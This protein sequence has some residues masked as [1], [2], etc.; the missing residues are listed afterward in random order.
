MIHDRYDQPS[1]YPEGPWGLLW[2]PLTLAALEGAFPTRGGDRH[3]DH[4]TLH[5]LYTF[6]TQLLDRRMAHGHLKTERR[7]A[8]LDTGSGY[9]VM[10][11]NDTLFLWYVMYGRKR[12]GNP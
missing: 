6:P 12:H 3:H 2:G 1:P 4:F 5:L 11:R 10:T 9:S 7:K 8:L